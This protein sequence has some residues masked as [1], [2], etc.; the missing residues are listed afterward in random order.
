M[1]T[2]DLLRTMAEDLGSQPL[3]RQA[4]LAFTRALLVGLGRGQDVRIHELGRFRC[5][6]VK[7]RRYHKLNGGEGELP[8][9]CQVTFSMAPRFRD[10]LRERRRVALEERS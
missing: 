8:P 2:R 7:G 5:K 1:H 9:Y 3:A 10:S 4:L 6:V